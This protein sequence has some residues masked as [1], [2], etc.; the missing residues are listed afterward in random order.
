MVIDVDVHKGVDREDIF[1]SGTRYCFIGE[2]GRE[3]SIDFTEDGITKFQKDSSVSVEVAKWKATFD[4]EVK[5]YTKVQ[6]KGQY[7]EHYQ[8]AIDYNN[9]GEIKLYKFELIKKDVPY[10]I[11]DKV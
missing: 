10:F 6:K 11:T 4:S 3:I 2:N 5:H 8:K 7:K 1:H 9:V